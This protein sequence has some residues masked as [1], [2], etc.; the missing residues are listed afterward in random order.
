MLPMSSPT[1]STRPISRTA[2]RSR[3][4]SAESPLGRSARLQPDS[5]VA[6]RPRQFAYGSLPL[7][8]TDFVAWLWGKITTENWNEFWSIFR[9]GRALTAFVDLM[10]I[11]LAF[12]LARR[13]WGTKAG[14]LAAAFVT[15]ATMHI[16][17]AHFFVM[18][19]WT[20]AFVTATLWATL[21][22]TKR[23]T[24]RA[25]AIAGFLAGCAVA[26][27]ATVVIIGM[28]LIVAAFSPRSIWRT[29]SRRAR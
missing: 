7:F 2:I 3:P 28:P 29:G 17:L 26:T 4:Q 15:V 24:P 18:D 16:Q 19:T 22:A 12:G 11:L 23:G 6:P 8:A 27:K 13:A 20:A 9:V 5:N 14:L 21:V 1:G 25:F 10:T